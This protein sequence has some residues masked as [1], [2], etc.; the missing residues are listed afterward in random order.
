MY[1]VFSCF[2]EQNAQINIPRQQYSDIPMFAV[3]IIRGICNSLISSPI[4]KC[5]RGSCRY[6]ETIVK[7]VPNL[8]FERMEK[9]ILFYLTDNNSKME[10]ILCNI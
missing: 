10:T 9:M 4:L 7:L 8:K 5:V 2:C 3:H 6:G 1:N